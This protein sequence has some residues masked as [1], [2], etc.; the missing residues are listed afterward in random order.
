MTDEVIVVDNNDSKSTTIIN[1]DTIT[2]KPE[3]MVF[4]KNKMVEMG[5]Y[6]PIEVI[7]KDKINAKELM[8][9]ESIKLKEKDQFFNWFIDLTVHCS[10]QRIY[11]ALINHLEKDSVMGKDWSM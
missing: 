3:P 5:Y 10:I 4:G 11:I 6:N 1:E 2:V 7:I 8:K 9:I